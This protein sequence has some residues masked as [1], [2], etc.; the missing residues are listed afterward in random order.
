MNSESTA[1]ISWTDRLK[2]A[3]QKIPPAWRWSLVWFLVV[4]VGLS[5]WGALIFSLD[6]VPPNPNIDFD[7]YFGLERIQEG[8]PGAFLGVWQRWDTNHYL[9]VVEYGYFPGEVTAFFPLY[10]LLS[11]G[12]GF[13]FGGNGLLGMLVVS[14]IAFALA[15]VELYKLVE[16]KFSTSIAR[17]TVVA[18]ILFPG[19]L[20]F[21]A[22]YAEPLAL[23]FVLLAIRMAR[24]ERWFGS[25]LAGLGAGLTLPT[26]LLLSPAL[27][28][29]AWKRRRDGTWLARAARIA[30]VAAPALGVVLFMAWRSY[31][32]FV[33]YAQVQF[34]W[35]GWHYQNPIETLKLMPYLVTTEYFRM[36]GWLNLLAVFII[37][38]SVVWGWRALPKDSFLYLIGITGLLI[39]MRRDIEPLASWGRHI[40]VAYPVFIAL[41]AWNE[42]IKKKWIQYLALSIATAM[43]LYVSGNY[44]M[45]GWI[46]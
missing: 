23:L 45:W 34:E 40:I 30:A 29:L 39:M 17:R 13:I 46:G 37:L 7:F 3:W 25:S 14:N 44:F 18:A 43:F 20:F 26:S 15:L 19:S 31:Q 8:L 10:P 32:G 41:G 16:V 2:R 35:W 11:R 33:P 21:F 24:Q 5:L 12:V 22:G 42:R 28:W 4:R 38:A 36:I 1:L 27:A 9:R 6:L